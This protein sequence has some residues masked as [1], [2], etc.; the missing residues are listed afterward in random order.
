MTLDKRIQAFAKLGDFLA[1]FHRDGILENSS[2]KE[3]DLFLPA[4][5]I[6]IKRAFEAN[7]WF[8]EENIHFAFNQWS[9]LLTIKNLNNWTESYNLNQEAAKNIGVIMAGN[10]PLVGF[11]D[12]LCVL[13]SGHSIQIKQ[14]SSDTYFLPLIAKFLEHIE[15]EFVGKIVFQ[16]ES[17]DKMDAV[18]ATGSNNTARYFDYYFGKYPHI[19]R[20]NRNS[21]AVLTEEDSQEDLHQLGE[22]IFRYFGLG[23][24]SVAKVLVPKGY[25]FDK[26]FE[27]IFPYKDL[28]DYQ[29]YTNNYDYNKAVYLMSNF[30]L[31]ENGFLM[32]KEDS[33]YAS[34][35]A[36]LFYET[37]DDQQ[38]L[39]HKLEEDKELIQC[40]VTN[41]PVTGSVGFGKTQQPKLSDYA[42]GV[43]TL[44]FLEKLT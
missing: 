14:S 43:D 35:I 31:L 24:R 21:V 3:N 8:T 16:K 7:G 13:I 33:S 38:A 42:D 28:I 2:I 4:F 30:K 19:I 15:P 5:K 44:K 41:L 32:L 1:Q 29:K 27:A 18:I 20:K 23:C 10:I 37:Y 26:L 34:P 22:D 11:H 40:V 25:D 9:N 36:T 17:L 6:Q 12:F 39:F